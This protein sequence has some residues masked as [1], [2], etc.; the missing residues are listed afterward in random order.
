MKKNLVK[1]MFFKKKVTLFK[2]IKS[3]PDKVGFVILKDKS[4]S[5]LIKTIFY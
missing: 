2:K 1:L 3:H 5:Q 4:R